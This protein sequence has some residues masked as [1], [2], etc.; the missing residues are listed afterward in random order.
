M[1]REWVFLWML[2]SLFCLIIGR[3]FCCCGLGVKVH[4]HWQEGKIYSPKYQHR[5]DALSKNHRLKGKRV[6]R[7]ALAG[8]VCREMDPRFF[9][10]FSFLFFF[11]PWAGSLDVQVMTPY[12]SALGW[13]EQKCSS[14][15]QRPKKGKKK[16]TTTQNRERA[17]KEDTLFEQLQHC[18]NFFFFYAPPFLSASP[19]SLFAPSPSQSAAPTVCIG[20]SINSGGKNIFP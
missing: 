14:V 8:R 19:S 11:L 17:L 2:W 4:Q 1:W 5:S 16:E 10:F 18:T 7:V 13:A 3:K 9:L 20:R 12:L 15:W 6:R